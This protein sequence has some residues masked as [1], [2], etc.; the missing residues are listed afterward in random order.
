MRIEKLQFMI[1]Y[2]YALEENNRDSDW[3]TISDLDDIVVRKDFI[4]FY[5]NPEVDLVC[6]S[7]LHTNHI[8]W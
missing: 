1:T 6:F 7:R 3:E 8:C 2:V 4:D 5:E